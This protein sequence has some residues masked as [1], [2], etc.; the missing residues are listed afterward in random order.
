MKSFGNFKDAIN[1]SQHKLHDYGYEIQTEKWQG[2]EIDDKHA[3]WETLNT[4]FTC[5][6]ANDLE[7]LKNQIKPNLPWADDHFLERVSRIP[8][9]PPPSHEWWPFSQKSNNQFREHQEFSHTY[10]ER[11]WPKQAGNTPPH[12][13]LRYDYGDF[14]DV[15][16]LLEREPLTRQAYLPMFFPEDTGVLHGG[17]IPCSIG[18]HFIRRGNWLH[19]VYQLR[20]CDIMR[21]FRD[22]IYLA[23]RKNLW[24]LDELKKRDPEKWNHILPGTLTMHVTSLHCFKNERRLLIK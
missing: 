5:P 24:V 8:Y 16:S 9:N 14:D 1:W 21:H 6:I 17:R 10:P 7:E 20:S 18:W 11:I 22:D 12:K 3:M 23:C 19:V 4:S 2:I 13:G 15:I